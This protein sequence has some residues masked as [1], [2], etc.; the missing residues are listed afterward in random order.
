MIKPTLVILAAGIGSRYG[1]LKQADSLGPNGESIIE[2]SIYDAIRS[3][4]GKVVIIIRKSIESDFKEKF[5]GKFHNKIKI[6][7]VFQELDS[8]IKGISKLP[9]RNKPWGT[10]HAMLMAAEVVQEPF[11][12]INADD[13]YGAESFKKIGNYL[14]KYCTA[15]HYC[16]VGYKL[17]N[18]LSENGHVS[19]GVCAT[20]SNQLLLSVIERTKIIKNDANE[21]H[22]FENDVP[23]NLDKDTIVSMNFWGFHP[24]IFEEARKMFIEFIDKIE[25][26][27]TAEFFIPLIANNMIHE[28]N[29]DLHVLTSDD[30]WYGVTYQ[31]DKFTVQKA[32]SELTSKNIYPTNLWV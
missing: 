13:F 16:M 27:S 11:L 2:Y 12:V 5:E 32:L 15:F 8:K 31:E 14:S 7:Y 25:D 9:E 4:F 23:Y 28:H 30:Q 6:V 29:V 3:G 18:T 21:I 24:T 26:G 20:D 22:Y 17:K 10:G 19:R 1:G